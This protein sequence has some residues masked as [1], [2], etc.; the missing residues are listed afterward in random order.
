MRALWYLVY[1]GTIFSG[2]ILMQF[3]K[4]YWTSGRFSIKSNIKFVL[5]NLLKKTLILIIIL[6]ATAVGLFFLL[7]DDDE[8]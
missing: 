3:F 1:C 2:S 5:H 8:K 6:G 7:K 4:L